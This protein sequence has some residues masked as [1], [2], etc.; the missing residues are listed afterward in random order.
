MQ[1]AKLYQSRSFHRCSYC[2]FRYALVR[3]GKRRRA[4]E[5]ACSR[6][7]RVYGNGDVDISGNKWFKKQKR[8]K[9]TLLVFLKTGLA[10]SAYIES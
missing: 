2:W 6:P 3:K 1:H 7:R 9:S 4:A 8:L 5:L 10:L